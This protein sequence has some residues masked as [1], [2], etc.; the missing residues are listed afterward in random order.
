MHKDMA[1]SMCVREEWMSAFHDGSRVPLS[2][3]IMIFENHQ[4]PL[5]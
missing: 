2:Q 1:I 5:M 4:L 3:L